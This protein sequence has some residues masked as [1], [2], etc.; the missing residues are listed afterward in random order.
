MHLSQ[1][2]TKKRIKAN[3]TFL[4]LLGIRGQERLMNNNFLVIRNGQQYLIYLQS[5]IY[6]AIKRDING[7]DQTNCQV[8]FSTSSKEPIFSHQQN[9]EEAQTLKFSGLRF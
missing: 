6:F 4:E 3:W 9:Q 8:G 2:V 1:K 7:K 5:K